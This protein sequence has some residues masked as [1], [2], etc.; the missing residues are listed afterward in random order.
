MAGFSAQQELHAHAPLDGASFQV[1]R[2]CAGILIG[3]PASEDQTQSPLCQYGLHH[4]PREIGE[5]GGGHRCVL[6]IA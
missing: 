2:L 4:L 3:D 1:R 6:L 5:Q